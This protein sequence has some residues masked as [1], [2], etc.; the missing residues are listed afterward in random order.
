M[1]Q[2]ADSGQREPL[3]IFCAVLVAAG[4]A[5]GVHLSGHLEQASAECFDA[6]RCSIQTVGETFLPRVE[7]AACLETNGSVLEAAK[8][9]LAQANSPKVAPAG[10]RPRS[11]LM[12]LLTGCHTCPSSELAPSGTDARRSRCRRGS[13]S[14]GWRHCPL[15]PGVSMLVRGTPLPSVLPREALG[16]STKVSC[17]TSAGQAGS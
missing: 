15:E 10:G 13:G 6:S 8:N 2:D 3:H 1:L 5:Q 12:L 16:S 4:H 11:G 14:D 7:A 17:T 9:L